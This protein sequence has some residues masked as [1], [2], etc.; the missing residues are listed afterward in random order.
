MIALMVKELYGI[1]KV[2]ARL[3]DPDK[4]CVYSDFG[5]DTVCPAVLSANEIENLMSETKKSEAKTL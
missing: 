2:I 3:Y 1:Q 5:I 4:G